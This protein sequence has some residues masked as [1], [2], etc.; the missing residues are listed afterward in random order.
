MKLIED[1]GMLFATEKSKK[2][3]D[4]GYMSVPLVKNIL[5]QQQPK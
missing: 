3:V 2:R 1:L 4:L 5:K